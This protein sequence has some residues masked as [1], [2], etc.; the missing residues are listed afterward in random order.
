GDTSLPA[1]TPSEH[2]AAVLNLVDDDV[3]EWNDPEVVRALRGALKHGLRTQN[4]LRDTARSL[5][6]C[7]LMIG[8]FI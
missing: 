8:D 7:L 6:S 5:D 3:I 4:Y 1:P 2:A